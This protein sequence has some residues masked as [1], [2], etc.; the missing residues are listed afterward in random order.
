MKNLKTLV[1]SNIQNAEI[2]QKEAAENDKDSVRYWDGYISA[3]KSIVHVLPDDMEEA[4]EV[5]QISSQ[6]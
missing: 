4:N 3:L 5:S 1:Y 2:R 6:S